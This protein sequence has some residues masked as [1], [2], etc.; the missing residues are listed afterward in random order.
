MLWSDEEVGSQNGVLKP[1]CGHPSICGG[2]LPKGTNTPTPPEDDSLALY[3]V[4]T[5]EMSEF[6]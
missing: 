6:G 4:T 1:Y 5:T 2:V 3:V